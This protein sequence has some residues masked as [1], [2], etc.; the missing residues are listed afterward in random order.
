MFQKPVEVGSLLL[1]SGQ[2]CYTE[3]NYIQIRVHSEVYNA[4]TK[5]HHTTNTFHFTF[6][7]ENEVPQVVPK[8]YGESMLYLDGK[9]H[10]TAVMKEIWQAL[11]AAAAVQHHTVLA[12]AVTRGG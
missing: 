5:E 12:R 6:I 7:S 1:L 2:V 8:T 4:N 3:K 9:R 10:F 11:G